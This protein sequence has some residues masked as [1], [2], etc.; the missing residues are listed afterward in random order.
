MSSAST[1]EYYESSLSSMRAL[2]FSGST[3]D[4]PFY[5]KKMESYLEVMTEGEKVI[6]DN[7]KLKKEDSEE[8]TKRQQESY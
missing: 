1:T 3:E 4:W 2:M 5:K 8:L 7:H 6:Q